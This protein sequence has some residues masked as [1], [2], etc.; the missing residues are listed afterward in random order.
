M[1][2]SKYGFGP[3]Y[4]DVDEWRDSPRRHRYVHGGFEGTDTR[5][6]FYFPPE[7]LYS[8][9]LVH[10]LE[11]GMGGHESTLFGGMESANVVAG[12]WLY[13]L[14][15]DELG[16]YLVES[17]Q[18]HFP[19]PGHGF[20]D[21]V[22]NFGAS[23]ESAR[24]SWKLAEE[25][26]GAAPH[27]SYVW[28]VSG[29]GGRTMSCIEFEPE[30]WD[31]AVP[32]MCFSGGNH[33]SWSSEGYWWLTAR[34]KL[35]EVVDAISPGGSGNPFESLSV[36]EAEGLAA[37]LRHGYPRPAVSQLWQFAPWVWQLLL[38]AE[39]N[40]YF[41]DFWTKP[42][43][44]GHDNPKKLEKHL[45]D[46]TA[47]VETAVRTS[48]VTVASIVGLLSA[49][50]ASDPTGGITLDVS[51][52]DNTKLFG[53]KLTFLSGRAKGRVLPCTQVEDRLLMTSV[54]SHLELFDGVE[55]GDEVHIENRDFIAWCHMF[56]HQLELP[57]EGEPPL[58][59]EW[60]GLRAW[61]LDGR[62]LY[63]QLPRP[64]AVRGGNLGRTGEFAGK[65]IHVNTSH[66]SMVWPNGAIGWTHEIE[67]AQGDGMWDRY[68]LW[69]VENSPHA[70]PETLLPAVTAVKDGKKWEAELVSYFG[71][72]AQALRDLV[73]WTE[74]GI[75]PASG[76]Q[77]HF[78]DDGG[79]V[80]P[81]TAEERG[82]VQP[83]A[84]VTANGGVRAEV[85]VGETVDLEGGAEQPPGM[86]SIVW[87]EW[88]VEGS[89]N[90]SV[91]TVVESDAAT[92]TARISHVYARP[93]TYF[94]T[95]RVGAHRDGVK[96]SGV[97]VENLARARVV[98]T[99]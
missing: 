1:T 8:G 55:P 16:A 88:D 52:D 34:H 87:S 23:A 26:Y 58:P 83:L 35:A 12:E 61:T 47:R 20:M 46:F 89:G 99:S 32:H 36:E 54:E 94:A 77:Y 70:E 82:G 37:V 97:A 42:G 28:G 2:E 65:V 81:S 62:P 21:D 6:S 7:E 67:A 18:G 91:R 79:L 49:G 44:L 48:E 40:P 11:G 31:G 78:T 27:H 53:A 60:G 50:A 51:L 10:Y 25:M 75:E 38:L 98:V 68:R 92:Y 64:E 93:G 74:D 24:Y 95:F 85:K 80:L 66:D 63:P 30:V 17:N 73:R 43:Y 5:F 3:A 19:A 59:V 39:I 13:N 9:R 45:I 90:R 84:W 72:T 14:A 69:W 29:G 33:S 71:V 76:A 56:L 86:G 22:E 41:Q 96:G 4:V 15:F 57:D